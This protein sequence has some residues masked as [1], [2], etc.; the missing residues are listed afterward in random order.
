MLFFFSHF[1]DKQ[2][3]RELLDGMVVKWF[4]SL[5]PAPLTRKGAWSDK[6]TISLNTETKEE[7]I[8]NLKIPERTTV[9]QNKSGLLFSRFRAR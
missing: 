1:P 7:R 5:N 2:C 3:F 6:Q 8:C 4:L 9:Y